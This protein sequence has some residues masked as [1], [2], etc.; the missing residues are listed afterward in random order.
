MNSW[1][2]RG[3]LAVGLLVFVVAGFSAC[4]K[5]A[6]PPPPPAPP[7]PT[8][9]APPSP[10]PAPA[11]SPDDAAIKKSVDDNLTKAGVKGVTVE[12]KDKV[13]T[14]TGKVPAADFQKAMQ[15]ANEATPK[16]SRV[17][18]SKLEKS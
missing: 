1:S 8:N 7:K 12:V 5:D 10:P 16:P 18:N 6:P 2:I 9:T 4:G 14:L 11:P 13:V 15:A 3:S 17:D